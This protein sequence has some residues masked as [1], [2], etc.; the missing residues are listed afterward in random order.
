MEESTE[1]TTTFDLGGGMKHT[2]FHGSDV[3]FE[4]ESGELTDYNPELIKVRDDESKQGNQLEDYAWKNR[5]GD[6]SQYFPDTLTNDVPILMEKDDYSIE[7]ALLDDFSFNKAELREE[8]RETPYKS[9]ETSD[10]TAVY[11]SED[12]SMS[13]EYTSLNQGV[14]ETIVLEEEPESNVFTYKLKVKDL[15]PEYL[16]KENIVVFKDKKKDDVQALLARPF[17]TDSSE[18][19]AYSRD[20]EYN[21]TG[22]EGKDDEY[23]LSLAVSAEYL[24]DAKRIYPVTIDPTVIWQGSTEVDVACISEDYPASSY[25]GIDTFM[26]SGSSSSSTDAYIK[27]KGIEDVLQGNSVTEAFFTLF[28]ICDGSSSHTIDVYRVTSPWDASTIC[29]NNQPDRAASAF[30]DIFVRGIGDEMHIIDLKDI[31]AGYANGTYDN[32]GIVLKSTASG[33]E[34]YT[35]F[36]GPS[37]YDYY[38]ASL[39]V[40]YSSTAPTAPSAVSVSK[41]SNAAFTSSSYFQR[42]QSIYANWS[43]IE[44]GILDKVQYKITAADSATS[45]PT[46]VG[47]GNIDMTAYQEFSIVQGSG[48]NVLIP[49]ADELPD[50]TY[51]L[52]IRGVDTGG[53]AGEVLACSF[54]VDGTAPVLTDVSVDESSAETPETNNMPEIGWSAADANF[55]KVTVKV[56]GISVRTVVVSGYYTVTVPRNKIQSTGAHAIT[57]TAED[58]AGNTTSEKLMYYVDFDDPVFESLL[59]TP[60]TSAANPSGNMSPAVSWSVTEPFI[61]SIEYKVGNGSYQTLGS[62]GNGSAVISAGSFTDGNG[63]Y[64][65]TFRATDKAGRYTTASRTYYLGGSGDYAPQNITAEEAYGKRVLTWSLDCFDAESKQYDLHRGSSAS[66]TPSDSTLIAE[67]L[68][69]TGLYYADAEVLPAGTYWYK[70]V[71]KDAEGASDITSDAVS[72]ANSITSSA[73]DQRTGFKDYLSYFEF[74]TPTGTGYIEKSSGNMM[75]EQTDYSVSNAQLDYGLDRT[76]NSKNSMTGMFGTGWSDSYHKELYIEGDSVHFMDSDGSILTFTYADGSYS[77]GESKEYTLEKTQGVFVLEDK[78]HVKYTFN[79][80]GQLAEITEPNG[81]SITNTYDHVGRLVSVTSKESFKLKTLNFT[82]QDD[83]RLVSSVTDFAGTVYAYTYSSDGSLTKLTVSR[84]DEGSVDYEYVYNSAGLMDTVIDGMNNSYSIAYTSG[85]AD[86]VTYPT[87]EYYSLSY[88]TDKNETTVTKHTGI[89]GWD[90]V[91]SESITYDQSTGKILTAKDVNDVETT[92]S[93]QTSGNPYLVARETRKQY[94]QEIGT[95]GAVNLNKSCNLITTYNYDGNDNLISETSPAGEQGLYEYSA[96]NQL[97]QEIHKS[98]EGEV[99]ENIT[100]TYVEEGNGNRGNPVTVTDSVSKKVTEKTY[101][102]TGKELVTVEK[103]NNVTVS[104]TECTYSAVEDESGL[105]AEGEE[106]EMTSGDIVSESEAFYDEMGRLL[107]QTADGVTTVNN[108]DFLGRVIKTEKTLAD[109]TVLTA[110]TEYNDNGSVAEETSIRGVTTEYTY[111]SLN[112]VLST[113]TSGSGIETSAKTTEYSYAQDIQVQTGL[114]AETV[115]IVYL[116]TEKDGSGNVLSKTYTG[117]DGNVVKEESGTAYTCYDYDLSGNQVVSYTGGSGEIQ[118]TLFDDEGRSFASVSE[119]GT[120]D[121]GFVIDDGS[122]TEYTGYDEY[123]N[124][125]TVTNG[126]GVTTEY[127]FDIEGR[128]QTQSQKNA[129]GQSGAGISMSYSEFASEDGDHATEMTTITDA[130][131]NLKKE[132]TD[133]AGLTLKITDENSDGTLKITREYVYDEKGNLTSEKYGDQSFILYDYDRSDRLVRKAAYDS[134]GREESVVTYTYNRFGEMV[135]AEKTAQ[136]QRGNDTVV[137]AYAWTYDI[138]GRVTSESVSYIEETPVVTSYEYDSEGRLTEVTYPEDSGLGSVSYVY[139]YL[140][141]LLSVKK[142]SNVAAEYGYDSLY[143]VSTVKQY[144][145]PGGSD[146]ILKTNTYGD[147]GRLDSVVYTENGVQTAVLESYAYEYDRNGNITERTRVNNLPESE[148]D[149][150]NERRN[151]T[152]SEFYDMLVS[153]E[154]R[155]DGSLV[156]SISYGYDNVGNRTSMTENSEATSYSYNGLNQ[157]VSKTDTAGT[158]TY[159]YDARGNQIKES[160]PSSVTEYSYLV[161]GEMESVKSGSTSSSSVIQ[162]NT[163]NHDGKRICKEEGDVTRNYYYDNGQVAYT[164]DGDSVSSANI[165]SL[166]DGIISTVRGSDYYTYLKDVQGSTGSVVDETATAEGVYAYSD[167]GEVNAVVTPDIDNEICY[168]GAVYDDTTGLHYLNA[169]YYDPENGRFLSQDTYRGTMDDFGQWHLYVYCSNNPILYVDP[170]GHAKAFLG[171]WSESQKYFAYNQNAPQKYLGYYDAYD[172]AA[173]YFGFNIGYFKRQTNKW[174][175][176]FWKGEYGKMYGYGVSSGCEIGLYY[177]DGRLWKCAYQKGRR[178]RMSMSLYKKGY[179]EKMFSRDSKTSTKQGKAWWLTGFQPEFY[180]P[181][182]KTAPPKNLKMKATIWFDSS[183]SKYHNDMKELS[184]KFTGGK[185]YST[186]WG[187]FYVHEATNW[188]KKS[189]TWKYGN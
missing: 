23:L 88:D 180:M 63:A 81:C 114:S 118:L 65:I 130:N 110:T 144:L 111:D 89:T 179:S 36:Y 136:V 94:Y 19:G 69:V 3:R 75:Y 137:S 164:M 104:T 90:K 92:Y 53:Q 98:S 103:E 7:M 78:A 165:I 39:D 21:L 16:E 159:D 12:G 8:E 22:I 44:S 32:Y 173:N 161:T 95:D 155:E 109:G 17:M 97:E 42:G 138:L 150:I 157:L 43:G 140:G 177:K 86:K 146:Y 28:D 115:D 46:S 11:E 145:T 82:Y 132:I 188:K 166:S 72:I 100:Y 29:W 163:Y 124:I 68:D 64:N 142:E 83:S 87:G 25:N 54:T 59:I 133:E 107:S 99:M 37:G 60:E 15:E 27:F 102:D 6:S 50:G 141:N 33:S 171:Y 183:D 121:G 51:K 117:P 123:G 149:K 160:S 131:G 18:D 26:V 174:K 108:Y 56:N 152:Y 41:T 79:S 13:I 119:P 49:H 189:I 52:H 80:S 154:I 178:L 186:D 126:R 2:T 156:S 14:K 1:N 91:Y 31:M 57:V 184:K 158:T 175:L 85:R 151:Y 181:G 70:F 10:L 105:F 30:S 55:S 153:T 84:R 40:T 112:R 96:D 168:T 167:F 169:R 48:S 134:T 135:T 129:S 67:D 116:E 4:D 172:Y 24:G 162:E 143:R 66:F 61:E 73:F 120:A 45:S 62:T 93:Y 139:D 34:K 127:I 148:G 9:T 176:E 106:M 5:T 76:Y 58:K 170:T 122:I 128:L 113:R 35:E 187:R 20:I 185:T 101:D 125:K 47:S 71:V 74:G 77:C 182:G 38:S 147:Y